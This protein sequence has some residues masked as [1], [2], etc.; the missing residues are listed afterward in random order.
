MAFRISYQ[1]RKQQKEIGYANDKHRSVYDAI[2]QA[3]GIDVTEYHR[4]E[5]QLANV[6]RNNR[7]TLKDFS[8]EYFSQLGFSH[9]VITRAD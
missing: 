8:E 5:S 3:E 1:Y 4:M 2:A 9:I 6:S 7:K